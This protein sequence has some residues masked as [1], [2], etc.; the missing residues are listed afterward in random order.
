MSQNAPLEIYYKA[1]RFLLLC[2]GILLMIVFL[3]L[4][5]EGEKGDKVVLK[6]LSLN[7]T[8][9]SP[10]FLA[11]FFAGLTAYAIWQF[12]ASWQV[13]TDAVINFRTNIRDLKLSVAF[14]A[15][16]IFAYFCKYFV[17]A[18][19]P[20]IL[21]PFTQMYENVRSV[22]SNQEKWWETLAGAVSFS[23]GAI[24]GISSVKQMYKKVEMLRSLRK[25][26]NARIAQTLTKFNW[27]LIFNPNHP[28]GSKD[29]TFMVDGTIGSGSNKNEA[30]W[31]VKDGF[32]EILNDQGA[33]F[34]RF[35]MDETMD[36]FV[37]T[38]DDDT[39]SLRG[40]RVQRKA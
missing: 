39:L 29:I 4:R 30:N 36:T 34:S 11:H 3:G 17:L 9:D 31:R 7:L 24:V 20:S 21:L 28:N 1:R 22:F 14:A 19:M 6:V 32:L 35:L 8:V 12:W 16:T 18:F 23:I 15:F 5:T 27:V 37:S 2:S 10:N 13:Q 33:V 26:V 40:Q 25:D 38:D